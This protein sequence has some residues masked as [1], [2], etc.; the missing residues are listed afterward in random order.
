M[1]A[2]TEP[3]VPGD[4][5]LVQ[6]PSLRC[7]LVVEEAAITSTT[8]DTST[9]TVRETQW[10]IPLQ[11]GYWMVSGP[12][13]LYGG[14]PHEHEPHK[15][16]KLCLSESHTV[17]PPYGTLATFLKDLV[18][19]EGE[20]E[21]DILVKPHGRDVMEIYFEGDCPYCEDG[22]GWI[23]CPPA[24]EVYP[25]LMIRHSRDHLCQFCLGYDIALEDRV[26][27]EML[28]AL[29]HRTSVLQMTDHTRR[30]L[31]QTLLVLYRARVA[32]I[33]ARK[34]E[35]GIRHEDFVCDLLH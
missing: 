10:H 15:E 5:L 7:M 33:T 4:L 27:M 29:Y 22:D 34:E 9:I 16:G 32:I 1:R 17:D 18:E 28:I 13:V 30:K 26:R 2:L 3:V 11:P 24:I 31:R 14:P 21:F 35:M 19:E 20:K 23:D 25:E 6:T 8:P 12:E